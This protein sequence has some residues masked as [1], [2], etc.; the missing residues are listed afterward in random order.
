MTIDEDSL[1]KS[2]NLNKNNSLEIDYYYIIEGKVVAFKHADDN[3]KHPLVK[4]EKIT[5]IIKK[6]YWL[7]HVVFIISLL[8]IIFYNLK[9]NTK[10]SFKNVI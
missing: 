8:I 10:P 6:K 2:N 5:P 1:L 9:K 4:V 3:Y 7:F